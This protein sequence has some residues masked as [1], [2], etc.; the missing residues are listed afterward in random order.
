MF[1]P[2]SDPEFQDDEPTTPQIS[3]ML[4]PVTAWCTCGNCAVMPTDKENVCCLEIPEIVR[5]INQV[6]DTPTC[7]THHP[8]FGPV[9]LNV[10]SLQNA[11]NVYKA[12]Y[13]PLKLKGIEQPD[14]VERGES[15]TE[16]NGRVKAV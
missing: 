10:Y 1:E 13:G 6:P 8:G 3:R 4:Q 12:D 2:E 16:C 15:R 9:C 14:G 11:L 7:M 5:R